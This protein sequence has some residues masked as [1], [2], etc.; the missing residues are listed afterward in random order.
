MVLPQRTVDDQKLHRNTVSSTAAE[1]PLAAGFLG[2]ETV[3]VAE[4]AP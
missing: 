2:G 4:L 3:K 1:R